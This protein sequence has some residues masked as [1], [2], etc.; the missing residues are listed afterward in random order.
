MLTRLARGSNNGK[1]RWEKGWTWVRSITEARGLSDT[2][3]EERDL[4]FRTDCDSTLA[5][6]ELAHSELLEGDTTTVNAIFIFSLLQ[7]TA[8]L[9]RSQEPRKLTL[10]VL[11]DNLP[12]SVVFKAR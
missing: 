8:H 2:S 4:F 5:L 3:E 1:V 12:C 11:L 9:K 7:S 6:G 10:Y